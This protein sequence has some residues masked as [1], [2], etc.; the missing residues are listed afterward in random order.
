MRLL[1]S[2]ALAVSVC[3]LVPAVASARVG[4]TQ[5]AI[6]V[7]LLHERTFARQ[8]PRAQADAAIVRV[9]ARQCQSGLAA[10]PA[11]ARRALAQVYFD[12]VAG[13]LWQ[14]D[15]QSARAW[16]ARLAPAA[17]AGAVWRRARARLRADVTEADVAYGR[18]PDDVC[19]VLEA[20]QSNGF[21]PDHRPPEVSDATRVDGRSVMSGAP[22]PALKRLLYRVGTRSARHAYQLL[23]A[24]IGE[25]EGRVIRHGDPVWAA[26]T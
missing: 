2:L 26:L 17:K 24:G 22:S 18:A 10:A 3:A 6:N 5:H 20:W 8:T 11:A 21:D 14:T 13:A 16:V 19:P 25:P 12:A 1:R 15:E 9:R 23:D 7:T 4:V